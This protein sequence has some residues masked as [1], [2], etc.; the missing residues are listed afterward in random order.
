MSTFN[1][2]SNNNHTIH[3]YMKPN[4]DEL[5]IRRTSVEH[6]PK[7]CLETSWTQVVRCRLTAAVMRLEDLVIY[8]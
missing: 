6:L 4:Y 3:N 2:I 8:C 1:K 5:S 7:H